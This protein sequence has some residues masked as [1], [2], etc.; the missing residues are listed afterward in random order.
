VVCWV[1]MEQIPHSLSHNHKTG[2]LQDEWVNKETTTTA[3]IRSCSTT[4]FVTKMDKVTFFF[5]PPAGP[6]PPSLCS[7]STSCHPLEFTRKVLTYRWSRAPPLPCKSFSAI[8]LHHEPLWGT[9][10]HPGPWIGTIYLS[11]KLGWTHLLMGKTLEVCFSMYF[12]KLIK[13][14]KKYCQNIA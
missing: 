3:I 14:L 6:S 10:G 13:I 2:I 12:N 4:K 9:F 5:Q 1:K 11:Q 8:Q 7:G